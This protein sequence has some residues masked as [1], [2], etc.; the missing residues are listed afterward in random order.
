MLETIIKD[1]SAR[2]AA[3]AVNEWLVSYAGDR[4]LAGT[5]ALDT[6][7]EVWLVPILYVYPKEGAL[8]S[9]GDIAVNSVTG[10]LS[11][12]PPIEEIKRLAL[13]LYR[14]KRGEDPTLLPSRD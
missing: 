5:P 10:E 8:G 13:D 3:A 11:A 14:V 1:I 6:R 9:V 7:S 4:F 12:H 2:Q